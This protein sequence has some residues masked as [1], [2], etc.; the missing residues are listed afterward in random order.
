MDVGRR[1]ALPYLLHGRETRVWGDQGYQGQT[2]VIRRCAPA[3]QDCTNRRHRQGGWIDETIKAKNREKSRVRAKV[4]HSIGVVKRVFGFQRSA[5]GGWRRTCT[6]WR[7]PP[8]SPT[9]SLSGDSCCDCRGSVGGGRE[10]TPHRS[11]VPVE[12]LPRALIGP[13]FAVAGE[14]DALNTGSSDLP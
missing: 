1:D 12:T 2:E 6:G 7:S 9:C 4:E 8:R 14:F 5:T 11:N 13:P 3:A 10:M